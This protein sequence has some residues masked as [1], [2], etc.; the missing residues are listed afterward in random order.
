MSPFDN[1]LYLRYIDHND[2]RIQPP[3]V[4]HLVYTPESSIFKC[5]HFYMLEAMHLTEVAR[6][7]AAHTGERGTNASHPGSV[8]MLSR[9]ALSLVIDWR[10]SGEPNPQK[11]SVRV[12]NNRS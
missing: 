8:R 5:G 7:C 6:A 3:G 9:I 2:I 4:F 11:P 1:L 12:A 10:E